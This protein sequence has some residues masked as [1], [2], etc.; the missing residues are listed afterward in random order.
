MG[1]AIFMLIKPRLVEVKATLTSPRLPWSPDPAD[2]RRGPRPR[3]LVDRHGKSQPSTHEHLQ[4]HRPCTRRV[5]LLLDTEH[6][7]RNLRPGTGRPGRRRP[8]SR[9]IV[10]HPRWRRARPGRDLESARQ[11]LVDVLHEPARQPDQLTRGKLGARHPPRHCRISRRRCDLEYVGTADIELPPEFGGEQTTHWAPEGDDCT[12]RHASHVSLG[13]ARHLRELESSRTIVH[14][15][16]SDLR[17][18]TNAKPL[19]SLLIG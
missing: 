13:C 11:A 7:G 19:S 17:H 3:K 6:A 9:S 16:S 4:I 18:W 5:V 12:R 1:A 10:I 2:H 8:R 14:L 15:T